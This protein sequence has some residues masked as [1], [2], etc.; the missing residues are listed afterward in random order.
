M[1]VFRVPPEVAGQRLDVFLQGQLH[2]TSRTRTQS[3]VRASAY[4]ATGRKLDP[5]D[6]VRS[7]QY[8]LLWRPAWDE[9]PSAAAIG[10]LY[11]DDHLLAIDKPPHLPVHP[12]ARYHRNTVIKA[13]QAARPDS[14]FLS[15]GH[16]LDRETSGVM[17][18]TKTRVCDRT[19]KRQLEARKG[20]EKTYV[21]FTWGVPAVGD[22]ATTF[23]YVRSVELDPT[24]PLR[25]K[26][27][28]SDAA[29]AP[30]AAT[31]FAVEEKRR[32]ADGRVY[33]RVRCELETGRQHQIRVH[34]ASLGTSVVGDKLYGPDERAFARSAD[35]ELTA[36]DIAML[37]MDRHALHAARLQLPHPITGEPLDLAAPFPAD[38]ADFWARLAPESRAAER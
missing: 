25:V 14:E 3:I 18:V 36:A 11:E 7:E 2:R 13:L 15:L 20:I 30:W 22:G 10:V 9:T 24:S 16:R 37:E 8:V 19:L 4:D 33:A 23:R 29:G 35:G 34:L 38:M 26:V 1:S 5:N 6:R 27:R 21:A 17:L 12:T 28:V 31:R 32:G